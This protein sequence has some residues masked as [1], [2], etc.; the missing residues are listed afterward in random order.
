MTKGPTIGQ[1]VT[2]VIRQEGPVQQAAIYKRLRGQRAPKTVRNWLY[3]QE[4][5]GKA[6]KD[7]EEK[8]H[9]KEVETGG[10]DKVPETETKD[11]P[12]KTPKEEISTRELGSLDQRGQFSTRLKSV[13]VK[14]VDIIPTLTDI[15]F[16]GDIEDLKWL[17]LVLRR[18]GATFV[19]TQQRRVIVS[20]WSQSHQLKF[21]PSEYDFEEKTEKK[22]TKA[23]EEATVL[24]A[25]VGY[26]IE[27]DSYGEWMHVPGGPMTLEQA[28]KAAKDRQIISAYGKKMSSGNEEEEDGERPTR[29]GKPVESTTDKILMKM[30]DVV[31]GDGVGRRSESDEKVARLEE[32]LQRMREDQ[33]NERFERIEGM[34]A[35]VAQIGNRDPWEEYD[36]IEKWKERLGVGAPA[37]TDSS[38]AVQLIKDSSDKVQKGVDRLTGLVERIV[39]REDLYHPEET[40]NP[41][42]REQKAGELLEQVQNKE[43]SRQVRRATFGR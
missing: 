6:Y 40:R 26:R 31:M 14:P 39:L 8:W 25:G 23:E 34:I 29:R 2:D 38:P 10:G 4:K 24:D 9:L 20:W 36:R 1:L 15:F 13:G 43:H 17:D 27:K 30:M 12:E 41:R 42:E 19:T 22:Q 33:M 35:Q 5:A 37:I 21:D 32:E 11:K 7:K 16:G 28:I 18:E 3:E